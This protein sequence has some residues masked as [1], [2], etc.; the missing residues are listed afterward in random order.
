MGIA[1]P[2]SDLPGSEVPENDLP[3][4][5]DKRKY[6]DHPISSFAAN[7]VNAISFGLPDYLN[8]KFT[9][10]TYAEGQQYDQANP[11]ATNLGTVTGDVA[12]FAI[13]AIGGAVKGAQ[14]G[15]RYA[16]AI[17]SLAEKLGA[18]MFPG[19]ANQ[20]STI[21]PAFNEASKFIK[22][23]VGAGIGGILGTQAGASLPGIIQGDPTKA[24]LGAEAVNNIPYV[25]SIPGPAQHAIPAIAAGA[26]NLSQSIQEKIKSMIQYE[27]AKKALG[28]GQ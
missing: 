19:A 6:E 3:G 25:P 2:E 21:S 16:P 7:A 9:P 8:K 10:E 15:A 24:V 5:L 12:G 18:K 28:Q 26:A 20:F 13:P 23:G 1:V 14:M 11:L 27:A 17:G 4:N 22:Q